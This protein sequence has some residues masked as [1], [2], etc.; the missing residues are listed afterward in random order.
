MKSIISL[1]E[2]HSLATIACMA[3]ISIGFSAYC[4]NFFAFQPC[5]NWGKHYFALAPLF[6]HGEKVKN[7]S[8]QPVEVACYTGCC[9]HFHVLRK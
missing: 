4:R 7:A 2:A 5:K 1:P 3:R 6:L 8:N 9:H